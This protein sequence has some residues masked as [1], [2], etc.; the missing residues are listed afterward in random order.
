MFGPLLMQYESLS[1]LTLPADNGTWGIGL[2]ASAKDA[3][4]RRL[5]DVDT[6]TSVVKG[7]PLVAHWLEGEPPDEGV[8]V[9]A[10]IE[11][12]HRTFVLD[13]Q[14]VATGAARASPTRG[15]VPTRPSAGGSTIGAIHAVAQVRDLLTSRRADPLEYRASAWHGA[16]LETVEPWYRGTLDFDRGRLDQI[17]CEMEGRRCEPD[18]TYEMTCALQAAALKD[19]EMLRTFMEIAG[20]V[21][22][23]DQ[24]FGAPASSSAAIELGGS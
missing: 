16:T 12:R 3:A 5:T 20:V 24:V 17:H 8:A 7:Y 21:T 6:W 22:V 23:P 18:P 14:P 13:G 19:A 1:I 10:K 11:D 15:R 9:M 2:V 4:L